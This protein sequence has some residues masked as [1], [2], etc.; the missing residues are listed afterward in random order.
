MSEFCE[1]NPFDGG[2]NYSA[3]VTTLTVYF[4]LREKSPSNTYIRIVVAA[5][6]TVGQNFSQKSQLF[7]LFEQIKNKKNSESRQDLFNLLFLHN[8]YLFSFFRAQLTHSLA[9]PPYC[10]QC[11]YQ[12]SMLHIRWRLRK[13]F[14]IPI[15]F[16]K[17]H[18]IFK[19][20]KPKNNNSG[21]IL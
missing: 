16:H 2:A 14:L 5:D 20:I 8:T 12:C 3:I 6:A 11:I 19:V 10:I 9:S 18:T 4:L 13:T 21:S 17:N 15:Y 1:S 7:C